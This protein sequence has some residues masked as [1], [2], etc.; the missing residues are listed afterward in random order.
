VAGWSIP[1]EYTRWLAQVY[2][3]SIPGGLLKYTTGVYQVVGLSIPLKYTRW[4]AQVYLRGLSAVRVLSAVSS[5]VSSPRFTESLALCETHYARRTG[6]SS[7]D[8]G[9]SGPPAAL[10]VPPLRSRA[11]SESAA[12]PAPGPA[13]GGPTGPSRPPPRPRPPHPHPRIPTRPP[14]YGERR[15]R[16]PPAAR[17]R[18]QRAGGSRGRAGR[19]E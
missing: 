1:L 6:P 18:G 10:R 19:P 13:T 17:G 12:A 11:D 14:T 2:H 16:R 5:L 15:C 9:G 7:P 4:L 3:W 8:S